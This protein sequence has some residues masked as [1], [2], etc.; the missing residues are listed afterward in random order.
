MD[1]KDEIQKKILKETEKWADY[2]KRNEAFRLRQLARF[3]PMLDLLK[4]LCA[5]IESEY[6]KIICLESNATIEMG[7][8]TN[9]E[10]K[11]TW[12]IE[13]DFKKQD[14]SEEYWPQNLWQKKEHNEEVPGFFVIE[15]TQDDAERILEFKSEKDVIG[16][17]ASEISKR[18]VFYRR[19][20]LNE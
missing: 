2:D 6:I 7:L 10:S 14:L 3:Q 12:S 11:I 5:S 1:P 20:K 18:V 16:H 4:E 17:L 19:N 9:C 15:R 13:P 8:D